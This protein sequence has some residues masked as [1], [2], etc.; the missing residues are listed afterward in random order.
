LN[1]LTFMKASIIIPTKNGVKYLAEVLSAIVNQEADF[2]Y[3]IVIVDSGSCDKTLEIIKKFQV[4]LL[5]IPP[6]D[7]NHGV[8]RNYAI[9]KSNGEYLVM[10]TQDATPAS[11]RWLASFIEPMERDSQLA[12][13]FGKQIPRP[14]CNPIDKRDL[15]NHFKNNFGEKLSIQEIGTGQDAVQKHEADKHRLNFFSNTNSCIRRSV[16]QKIPFQKLDMAEDQ[17]WAHD[18]LFAGYKKGYAPQAAV[19]HSHNYTPRQ[20]LKRFVDEYRSHK[21]LQNYVGV[22]SWLKVLPSSL[23]LCYA[24][25]RYINLQAYS[26]LKKLRWFWFA[27]QLDF[28]RILGE[29]LGGHYEKMPVWFYQRISMQKRIIAG[30]KI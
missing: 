1:W 28:A 4:K 10:L 26:S 8:T 25:C 24:D 19:W 16:W 20:Y 7:F 30:K 18:V 3:E 12:G 15:E 13:L 23:R 21:I 9:S 2:D 14:D 11:P 22:K 6:Q 17:R 29:Y 5:Q 27:M